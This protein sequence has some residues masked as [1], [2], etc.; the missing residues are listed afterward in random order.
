[1]IRLLLFIG[2][3]ILAFVVGYESGSAT[4]KLKSEHETRLLEEKIA[5]LETSH[6]T[7]QTRLSDTIREL[8]DRLSQE[9]NEDPDA[10]RPAI[11]ADGVRR[12]G[13][14]NA[15]PD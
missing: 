8:E 14:I 13:E 4:V 12:I 3:A 10:D 2:P 6:A 9:A 1:M 15:N 5:K 11:D 7:E